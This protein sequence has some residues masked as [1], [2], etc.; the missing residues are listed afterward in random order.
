MKKLIAALLIAACIA[1]MALAEDYTNP[2][3]VFND[4][5]QVMDA[6]DPFVMRYNGRYYLYTT[7]AEEIRCYSSDDLVSWNFEGHCT[8]GGASG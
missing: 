8:A 3:Q 5:G 4:A 6:A 2:V 1:G 7:G